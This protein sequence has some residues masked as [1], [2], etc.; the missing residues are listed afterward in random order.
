M[1]KSNRSAYAKESDRLRKLIKRFV[2]KNNLGNDAYSKI[3]EQFNTDNISDFF[4]KASAFHSFKDIADVYQQVAED[5]GLANK[6]RQ[7]AKDDS[8]LDY[9]YNED[10]Y[11]APVSESQMV[12]DAWW[13]NVTESAYSG[14]WNSLPINV[15]SNL[16][17]WKDATI[18]L[19]GEENFAD[20]IENKMSYSVDAKYGTVDYIEF[21][22]TLYDSET[23]SPETQ[24]EVASRI[25]FWMQQATNYALEYVS[26]DEDMGDY[27][28]IV[29]QII[30]ALDDL[31]W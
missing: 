29:G 24:A 22:S 1:A 20:L 19:I 14:A 8:P 28:E 27:D 23:K 16:K 9:D 15:Y 10:P 4:E 5:L 11:Q 31:S 3:K 2:E 25:S 30:D 6:Q 26:E 7:K 13:H 12:I 17:S 21:F 18:Q